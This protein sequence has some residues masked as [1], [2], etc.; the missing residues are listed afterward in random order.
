MTSPPNRAI[1]YLLVRAV[2]ISTKQHDK[3]NAKGHREFF[4]PH[5]IISSSFPIKTVRPI[6]SFMSN[7]CPG[8]LLMVVFIRYLL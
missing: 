2:A 4:L 6:S 8:I 7:S 1:S 3:P 5:E